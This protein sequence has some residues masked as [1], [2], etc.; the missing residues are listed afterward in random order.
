MIKLPVPY[1]SQF[2]NAMNPGGS[3]NVTSCAMVLAYAGY[4]GTGQGQFEDQLYRKMLDKGW[5]RHSPYDLKKLL[6]SYPGIRDDFRENATWDQVKAHL[7][8]KNPCIL[9]A[10][11]T[12]S[13]HVLPIIGDDPGAYGGKGGFIFNDPAGEWTRA[14]Y[15]GKTGKGVCYSYRLVDCVGRCSIQGGYYEAMEYYDAG[16]TFPDIYKTVMVHFVS[17]RRP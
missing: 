10:D 13:G 5:S 2:D 11:I 9:H 1:F 8:T 14:G 15:T 7:R 3:C 4:V 12:P 16:K 6:E 17:G